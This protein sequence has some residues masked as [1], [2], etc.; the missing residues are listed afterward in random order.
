MDPRRR[1]MLYRTMHQW[2]WI[3]AGICLAALLLFSITGIT[4]NHSSAISA[5]PR[6]SK[7]EARLPE[8]L[9]GQLAGAHAHGGRSCPRTSRRG[10]TAS[11]GC[12]RAARR[13]NGR[14]RSS[15][16]RRPGPAATHGC[17]STAKRAPRN[18][19]P[20]IAAG[21]RTSTTCTRAATPASCGSSSSTWSPRP[22]CSSRITGPGVAGDPGKTTQ[23]D[24]A[25][26]HG[27]IGIVVA[28]MIFF[29]H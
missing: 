19:K 22:A 12:R 20:P 10:S 26:G 29:A 6:V 5:Q 27:G 13:L 3:S 16:Y 24:L 25:A 7:H 9:R 21:W 8:S 23:V 17:P 15:I 4:L 14:T 28:L 2:H 18:P 11:S 1:M